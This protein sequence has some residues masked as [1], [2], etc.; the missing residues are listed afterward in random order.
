MWLQMPVVLSYF[1]W[2]SQIF[3][4]NLLYCIVFDNVMFREVTIS[5]V[6]DQLGFVFI[7]RALS[8]Q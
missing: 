1:R 5:H 3:Q 4:K 2:V 7:V 8:V 6:R